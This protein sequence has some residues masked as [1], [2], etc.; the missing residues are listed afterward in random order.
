MKWL[1]WV[2]MCQQFTC[3]KK[4][5]VH[6]KVCVCVWKKLLYLCVEWDV[7]VPRTFCHPLARS[8]IHYIRCFI[9][10]TSYCVYKEFMYIIAP[11]FAIH[12]DSVYIIELFYV[13]NSGGMYIQSGCILWFEAQDVCKFFVYIVTG[14]YKR[15]YLYIAPQFTTQNDA[16]VNA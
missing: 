12:N 7:A 11:Q 6:A 16:I 1:Y 8:P 9:I 5:C 13:V 4:V 14:I 3:G 10:C 15:L 2:D